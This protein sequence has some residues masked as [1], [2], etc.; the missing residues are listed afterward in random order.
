[1]DWHINLDEV[2][3]SRSNSNSNH[4]IIIFEIF[5]CHAQNQNFDICA[6]LLEVRSRLGPML[7]TR[8][9]AQQLSLCHTD[10]T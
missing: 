6:S 9:Q 7:G 1:M 10:M 5:R 2:L 3:I 4:Q 8:F